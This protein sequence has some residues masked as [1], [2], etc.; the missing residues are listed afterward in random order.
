MTDVAVIIRDYHR[1]ECPRD[2]YDDIG[3]LI[4]HYERLARELECTEGDLAVAVR[5]A[6]VARA[7]A[8]LNDAALRG[9]LQGAA[10]A[11]AM[12]R[13]IIDGGGSA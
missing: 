1:G 8:S 12:Y 5:E 2:P 13:S 6:S 9:A 4:D 10:K 7:M 11:G 3:D